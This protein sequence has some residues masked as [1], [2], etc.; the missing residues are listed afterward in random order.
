MILSFLGG[1]IVSILLSWSKNNFLYYI[2]FKKFIENLHFSE[3]EML[4]DPLKV[5]FFLI[6]LTKISVY[7]DAHSYRKE[8]FKYIFFNKFTK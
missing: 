5:I 3:R 1:K 7:F 8:I 6:W 2:D 4:F